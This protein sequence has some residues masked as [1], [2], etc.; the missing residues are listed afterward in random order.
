MAK[1]SS[2]YTRKVII[3]GVRDWVFERTKSYNNQYH[4]DFLN[5]VI[6]GKRQNAV[7]CLN[8]LKTFTNVGN[9]INQTKLVN[10]VR[11]A[12]GK[13]GIKEPA[14]ITA[15][16][17]FNSWDMRRTSPIHK[18][19]NTS[20]LLAIAKRSNYEDVREV[21]KPKVIMSPKVK[22]KVSSRVIDT[23][24]IRIQQA[25]AD[26]QFSAFELTQH[27]FTIPE[28]LNRIGIKVTK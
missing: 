16:N 28:F 21:V 4:I 23:T 8:Y 19:T 13:M 6:N 17:Y 25:L 22:T 9:E 27:K 15:M 10:L 5:T 24:A 2:E 20:S 18:S 11:R 14:S 12:V 1:R 7:P 3:E 26:T